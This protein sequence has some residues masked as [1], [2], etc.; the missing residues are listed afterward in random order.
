ML[1]FEPVTPPTKSVKPL[2]YGDLPDG[3]LIRIISLWLWRK[4]SYEKG[5]H[6]INLTEHY[7]NPE[8]HELTDQV[9]PGGK[10]VGILDRDG[11]RL[12]YTGPQFP[13]EGEESEW[14]TWGDLPDGTVVIERSERMAWIVQKEPFAVACIYPCVVTKVAVNSDTKLYSGYKYGKVV[15]GC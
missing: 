9:L 3:T 15:A 7:N 4:A 8:R 10:F 13:S 12:P 14:K 5:G 2:T 11:Q 6:L 1:K